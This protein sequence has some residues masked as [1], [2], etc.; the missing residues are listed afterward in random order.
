MTGDSDEVDVQTESEMKAAVPKDIKPSEE[1]L[2]LLQST[3][4]ERPSFKV[5]TRACQPRV[6][7]KVSAPVS[8][9]KR[10]NSAT[11]LAD[12]LR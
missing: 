6:V 8:A 1:P 11:W 12:L 3:C 10:L 2:P 9:D 4:A 7:R 5:Y